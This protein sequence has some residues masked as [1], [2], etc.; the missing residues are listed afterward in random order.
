MRL[1]VR[2]YS[3]DVKVQPEDVYRLRKVS[4]GTASTIFGIDDGH[5]HHAF[6]I[7]HSF[8]VLKKLPFG[9]LSSSF[10]GRKSTGKHI[11]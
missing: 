7:Q 3:E 11:R 4:R 1:I 10:S 8:V 2:G 5:Q 9:G 6:L